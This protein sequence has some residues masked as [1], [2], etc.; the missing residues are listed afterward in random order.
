MDSLVYDDPGDY[1]RSLCGTVS[2]AGVILSDSYVDI[3]TPRG[4][5]QALDVPK[6]ARE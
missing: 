6:P 3:G 2:I 4:L 1:L 5:R